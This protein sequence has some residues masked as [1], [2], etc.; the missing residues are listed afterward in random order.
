MNNIIYVHDLDSYFTDIII[1]VPPGEDW[2]NTVDWGREYNN[3][4]YEQIFKPNLWYLNW[5]TNIL[6]KLIG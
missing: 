6:V 5:I 4:N 1:H 3:G 2:S